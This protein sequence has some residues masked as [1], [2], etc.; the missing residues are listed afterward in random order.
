MVTHR[1]DA[2]G[3][4]VSMH[5]FGTGAREAV[6]YPGILRIFSHQRYYGAHAAVD[7]RVGDYGKRNV[8]AVEAAE[9]AP[10]IGEAELGYDVGAGV[11]V[12]SCRESHYGHIGAYL[13]DFSKSGVVGSEIVAPLR[14]AMGLIDGNQRYPG[15]APA[16]QKGHQTFRRYIKQLD[17]SSRSRAHYL[18]VFGFRLVG[19]YGGSGNAVGHKRLGLVLHE[20]DQWRHHNGHTGV[21]EQ[22]GQL[23]AYALASAG[24][25]HHHHVAAFAYGL[26]GFELAGAEAAVA[27]EFCQEGM[28]A[29][30]D[31]LDAF[32]FNMQN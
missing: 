6:G 30:T 4:E 27:V 28:R 10:W 2:F 16:V 21:G 1:A 24:G 12:G 14:Y 5:F 7:S 19:M 32:H 20:C 31:V 22:S 29:F 9:P 23:V 26:D 17:A 15:I 11:L 13:P 18:G 8:W 25:H 3:R